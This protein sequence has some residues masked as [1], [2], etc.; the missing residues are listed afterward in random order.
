[1][2]GAFANLRRASDRD[3]AWLVLCLTETAGVHA[4]AELRA[5]GAAGSWRVAPTPEPYSIWMTKAGRRL[6]L[7]AGRQVAAAEDLEVLALGTVAERSDGATLAEV[8]AWART[9]GARRV[10]P[11]GP[12]KWLFARGA[13]LDGLLADA[14]PR[15]FFLGDER[16]RPALWGTPRHF[17]RAAARGIRV[18]PGTDPLPFPSEV[19]QAGSFGVRLA[20]PLDE[21]RPGASVLAALGDPAIP[22][23]PYGELET[24]LRFLRHQL[25]M[26]LLKRRRRR[27]A[28][29][30]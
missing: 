28:R 14:D 12:G 11:W 18:L 22:L 29:K 16:H 23:Q 9:Q 1:L 10:I 6:L 25:A 21:A 8:L 20:A 27:A 24:P 2:D 13:L 7:V 30:A 5:A 15:D 19:G 4:F 17:H 3:D 26:Q